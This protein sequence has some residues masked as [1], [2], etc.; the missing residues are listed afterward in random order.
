MSLL[1]PFPF[2]ALDP[3][4]GSASDRQWR[5]LMDAT[6]GDGGFRSAT[7]APML[8]A[9][10][11]AEIESGAWPPGTRLPT[12]RALAELSGL[13]RSAI[14]QALG[15][16][17][18]RGLVER[19]HGSGTYVVD[20]AAADAVPALSLIADDIAPLHL[21]EVRATLEPS[22]SRLAARHATLR[23]LQ[24]LEGILSDL[25]RVAADVAKFAVLDE[26]FHVALAEA[27]RNPMMVW[28]YRQ[29]NAVRGRTQWMTVRDEKLT[30]ERIAAYNALHRDIFDAVAGRNAEKAAAAMSEHMDEAR[31]DF[32]K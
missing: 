31:A 1:R 13:P 21:I 26:A 29:M 14:R 3:A 27:T 20:P 8:A 30:S 11:G 19:R 17:V 15:E 7:T 28:L 23:D 25:D 22:V 18:H 32:L 24:V 16:L 10:L 2:L 9:M 6:T 12:E 5:R 4:V